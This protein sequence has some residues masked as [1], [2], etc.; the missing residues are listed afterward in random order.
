[1]RALLFSALLLMLVNRTVMAQ[2]DARFECGGA[3]EAEI[4]GVW[5]ANV[6]NFLDDRQ[7]QERL[8]KQGDVYALY[9]FETY[10]YNAASMARRCHRIARLREMAKLIHAAYRALQPGTP[11]SPGRRWVCRGGAICSEK[12]RLL[13]NEV[14]LDSAQFLGLATS[15]AGALAS[16]G[17]MDEDA[18]LFI[19]DT[20]QVTAEHLLRWGD[21]AGI[22]RLRRLAEATP[23]D[24]ENN[25]S[26]LFFS[27]HELWLIAI[28]AE[29]SGLL[30]SQARRSAGQI[31]LTDDSRARMR[32]HLIALLRF[33]AR[34]T[35][36]QQAPNG[37]L[38]G[39]RTA[40]LDR[41]YW[42]LLDAN[43][44]AAYEQE[45]KPVECVPSE[46]SEGGFKLRIRV[47][48][49]AV[50][51]RA[52]IGWDFSHMRRLVPA[53][54]ALERNRAAIIEIFHLTEAQMPPAGL[55]KAFAATLVSTIWNGD[56]ARPLFANYWS[57]ANGWYRVA[58]DNGS[59]KC[60]E[61]YPPYGMSE[62]FLT[63]GYIAWARYLP[64]IGTLGLTLYDLI[65]NPDPENSAF[66]AKY[67]S[68]LAS[69][70]SMQDRTLTRFMF[71]PSLVATK[72]ASPA[73]R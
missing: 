13:N 54:D 39:L 46:N 1:M 21:D 16:S 6:R 65:E 33:F 63:G 58:Y 4:W 5:D 40:D 32:R 11:V 52:D 36:F 9:D 18:D 25:S 48:P 49:E 53:L 70:A 66:T 71:L 35:S 29:L 47:P 23:N 27:D 10:I 42:R 56:P 17:A 8:L 64:V 68:G 55:G 44:Y 60:V 24:V 34:R 22:D 14:A 67:Y 37:P 51:R 26:A 3:V 73:A 2:Q 7:L 41:G 62:A 38:A 20:I 57:G 61:G 30:Q 50:R 72:Q 31:R 59:G 28:Y 45:T 69:T 43:R 15:V 19:A 12:N